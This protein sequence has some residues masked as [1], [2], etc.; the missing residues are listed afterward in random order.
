MITFLE[1]VAKHQVRLAILDLFQEGCALTHITINEQLF[2]LTTDETTDLF[3]TR[4]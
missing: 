3:S 2:T 4:R 1:G